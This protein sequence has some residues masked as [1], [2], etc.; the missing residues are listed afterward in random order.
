MLSMV[1]GGPQVE[2]RLMSQARDRQAMT[3]QERCE[4]LQAMG[5]SG[6]RA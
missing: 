6:L 2:F 5:S 4:L 3:M 1:F